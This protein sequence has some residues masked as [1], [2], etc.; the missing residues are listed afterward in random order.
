MRSLMHFEI[1]DSKGSVRVKA[2]LAPVHFL[3]RK[4]TARFHLALG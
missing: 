1:K 4:I 2:G 3:P